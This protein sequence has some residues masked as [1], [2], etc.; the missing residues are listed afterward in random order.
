MLPLRD[1]VPTRQFPV[2]TAGL[3]AAN[4]VV[5]LWEVTGTSVQH[6]VTLFGYYPCTVV[7]P[8]IPPAPADPLPWYEGVFT[9]MFMHGGW[10]HI[11]GNMLFLWI[12]GNNIEDSLGRVRF[13][14]WYIAAGLAA[15]GLQTVVTLKAGTLQD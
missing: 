4:V 5:W 10:L 11:A 14:V 2:V 12:F 1:N 6:D 8:C 9:S 3:I 13:F 15:T 7:G